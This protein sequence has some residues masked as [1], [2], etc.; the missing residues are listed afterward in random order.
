LGVMI[1]RMFT[2]A[3]PFSIAAANGAFDVNAAQQSAVRCFLPPAPAQ[4][5]QTPQLNSLLASMLQKD[6]K[7]RPTMKKILENPWFGQ[8]DAK[9]TDSGARK[10]TVV[11]QK[12]DLHVAL[13]ADMASRENLSQLEDVSKL[14][15]S[16]DTDHG[17]TVSAAEMRNGLAGK[18]PED[19]IE[20]LLKAMTGADG[21]ITYTQ[22]MGH[23]IATR[24]QS[25]TQM[26]FKLFN[27]IDDD[28]NGWL[29]INEINQMLQ[30]PQVAEMMGGKTGQ[31][32]MDEID[33]NRSGRISWPEFQ[34]YL[35]K[36]FSD[37]LV[38]LDVEYLSSTYNQWV[39]CKVTMAETNGSVMLSCKPNFWFEKA[40]LAGRVR[41]KDGRPL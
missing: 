27:E 4:L 29:D 3:F 38:G 30:R 41:R 2:G 7:G 5:A 1:Y 22:F 34:R 26:L 23:M 12:K 14:F 11:D 19:Q 6:F 39:P 9:L 33:D 32:L 15:S 28:K 21:E 25:V 16:L 35:D 18:M 17:G 13:L 24:Q 20:A 36:R 37:P 31:Q 10:M 40:S 8:T